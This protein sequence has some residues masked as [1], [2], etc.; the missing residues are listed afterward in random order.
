MFPRNT[1]PTR[2][3]II[4]FIETLPCL[5]GEEGLKDSIELAIHA[6][7]TENYNGQFSNLYAVL[8]ASTVSSFSDIDRDWLEANDATG[9]YILDSLNAEFAC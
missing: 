5:A 3:T 7:A 8:S 6:F 1:D 4:E 2:E 9:C